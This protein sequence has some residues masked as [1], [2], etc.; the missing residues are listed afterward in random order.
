M[1]VMWLPKKFILLMIGVIISLQLG[2]KEQQI[3][4]TL[5]KLKR[6]DSLFI[7][8]IGVARALISNEKL[9]Q[10]PLRLEKNPLRILDSKDEQDKELIKNGPKISEYLSAHSKEHFDYV[11]DAAKGLGISFEIDNNLV[12]GLDYY[13]HTVFELVTESTNLGISQ[14]SIL[15]GGR[16]N[17]LYDQL[18]VSGHHACFGWG[19]GVDRIL[20]L[21]QDDQLPTK[22]SPVHVIVATTRFTDES[23]VD[24][25]CL[26]SSAIVHSFKVLEKFAENKIP[27]KLLHSKAQHQSPITYPKLS[28]QLKSLENEAQN[29]VV[30][31]NHEAKNNGVRV[32]N[33]TSKKFEFLSVEDAV[34]RRLNEKNEHE[35][36][37]VGE[38]N[39]A[40]SSNPEMKGENK[41]QQL[42]LKS[43]STEKVKEADPNAK[44][45]GR[46]LI[47]FTCKV[48]KHRQYKSV[49]K[50]AYNEGVVLIKCDG[51][52]N[53]HLFADHLG[54]FRDSRLTIEDLM[55][56]NGEEVVKIANDGLLDVLGTDEKNEV[57]EKLKEM[58]ENDKTPKK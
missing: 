25:M 8:N 45:V 36:Q 28:S 51:C 55:K 20:L 44:N 34:T 23:D 53:R 54:W 50:R 39:D 11:L 24:S 22:T 13:D 46:F 12:R 57:V 29:V 49:S 48:C 4:I 10:T 35:T 40:L 1:Q 15:A 41:P 26:Q 6:I 38:A 21:I 31:G 37:V 27:V 18:G 14:N 16:Y 58:F 52:Q 7:L 43:D 3:F 5:E 30:I 42:E 2:R 33:S 32:R 9:G 17:G 56:E 47:G 19:A